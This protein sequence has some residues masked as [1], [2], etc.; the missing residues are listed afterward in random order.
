MCGA[1]QMQ[2]IFMFYYKAGFAGGRIFLCAA[3]CGLSNSNTHTQYKGF[4]SRRSRAV[5]PTSCDR[6]RDTNMFTFLR[7]RRRRRLYDM[8]AHNFNKYLIT[9]YC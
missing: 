2:F 3:H 5:A 6:T 9:I 7:C 8:Y 4:S 1:G